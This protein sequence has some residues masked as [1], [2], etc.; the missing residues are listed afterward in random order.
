MS[1]KEKPT[2][3][4]ERPS[5]EGGSAKKKTKK[6][7]ARERAAIRPTDHGAD[8]AADRT[9][10]EIRLGRL[11]GADSLLDIDVDSKEE[12]L[13]VLAE[14]VALATGYPSAEQILRSALER[15]AVVNTYVGEGVAVPHARVSSF[16]GFAIAIARNRKGF[17]YGVETDEPVKLVILLVG[18]EAL[19]N[20][21]V[22]LLADIAS[23]VRDE[24]VR[25]EILDLP[26]APS[27][28]RVLDTGAKKGRRRRPA[29]ITR[30]LLSHARKIAQG[31]G[32]NAVLVAVEN[33]EELTILKR[34]PQCDSFIV[35]TRSA[36][37]AESA[38]KIVSRVIRLPRTPLGQHTFVRLG[39][40][41]GVTK[42]FISR[43]D[44]VAFISGKPDGNLDTITVIGIWKEFGRFLTASGEVSPKV[45]HGVLERVV[46]LTSELGVEGRE[47]KPIGT[48]FVIGDPDELAPYCQQLIINPFR[49]YPEEERNILDPTLRETVKEFAS[50]D[51]AFIV[52]GDGVIHSAGTYLRPGNVEVDLPG[53]FGTRHRAACAITAIAD[54]IAVTLS[55]S[56]NHLTLFK[57]G[58]V[59][60]S[61]EKAPT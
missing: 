45:S 55:E 38:E 36:R 15:E 8:K 56:T 49:G 57:K 24:S 31:V 50:I 44:V 27:V 34:L 25:E 14:R 9:D 23:V 53:G 46:I 32:A 20:E 22:R 13:R 10:G 61:T 58:A 29:Q 19:Q 6:R 2:K 12:L 35:A 48:I 16:D 7:K 30:M 21:H 4:K 54:C 41:M 18:N 40:L 37:I 43:D 1:A 59:V 28:A 3:T 52:K 11:L 60:L 39:T 26:D 17:P 5:R 51:G 33:P 42:G 47:G